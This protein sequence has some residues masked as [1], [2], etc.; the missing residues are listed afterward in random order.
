MSAKELFFRKRRTPGA[1]AFSREIP[2][3]HGYENGLEPVPLK[4]KYPIH[5]TGEKEVNPM[6]SRAG[7][8]LAGG[9]AAICL[10]IL[11]GFLYQSA[12]PVEPDQS[13]LADCI[14]DR[15]LHGSTAK[16]PVVKLYD[17]V[18]VGERTYVLLELG[19]NLDLGHA[20]LERSQTGRYRVTGLGYGGGNFR[21]GVVE[22]D[23]Q[24]YLLF[25]GRNT[26]EEIA[27]AVF[28]LDGF[29]YSLEIPEQPRFLV[30]TEID[31][32]IESDHPDLEDLTLYNARGEDITEAYNLS[33]GGI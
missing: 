11:A 24:K 3:N 27:R 22:Q 1:L 29:S 4:S 14:Q 19:E 25:G 12:Y 23:G 2:Y 30:C 7:K 17:A 28:T 9:A 26:G 21:R 13:N 32:R 8:W 20:I 5:D 15:Y 16:P 10:L 31:G 33:G 18:T 6:K